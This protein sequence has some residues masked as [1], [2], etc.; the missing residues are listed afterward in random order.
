MGLNGA[1]HPPTLEGGFVRPKGRHRMRWLNV[2]AI[3][4][5]SIFVMVST[6]NILGI[7]GDWGPAEHTTDIQ[8]E[9]GTEEEMT[10]IDAAE[11]MDLARALDTDRFYRG[12]NKPYTR[13]NVTDGATI[14]HF[15]DRIDRFDEVNH[16]YD[17]EFTYRV[18]CQYVDRLIL[19]PAT[20]NDHYL[21][22]SYQMEASNPRAVFIGDKQFLDLEDLPR[23]GNGYL[24]EGAYI[25][26]QTLNYEEGVGGDEDWRNW[27]WQLV[28]LDG[29]MD[30]RVL[31]VDANSALVYGCY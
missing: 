5:V 30:L 31:M 26:R 4:S 28:I 19:F 18:D 3:A 1:P 29:N 23:V 22:S 12:H 8:R 13:V 20:N 10:A 21:S 25:I 14:D 24:L 11:S 17:A 15:R 16:R 2:F 7:T 27:I 6:V 9:F